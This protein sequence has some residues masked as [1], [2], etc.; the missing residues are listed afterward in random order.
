MVFPRKVARFTRLKTQRI[1]IA[2]PFKTAWTAQEKDA[3]LSKKEPSPDG[4]LN[5][6]EAFLEPTK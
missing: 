2:A 5:N 3:G 6:T 1:S 4:L